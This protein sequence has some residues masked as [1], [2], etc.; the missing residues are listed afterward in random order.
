MMTLGQR[1]QN[2]RREKGLTQKQLAEILGLATG[3]I[4]QY[5][6]DKRQPRINQLQA[7]AAA[8]NVSTA[9]LLGIEPDEKFDK[10]IKHFPNA[11]AS[12]EDGKAVIKIVGYDP[13]T[14]VF[15][16]LSKLNKTGQEVAAERIEE[17]T[18]IPEYQ[19]ESSKD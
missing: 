1:I 13:K 4:Q 15:K 12:I 10:L 3:T 7:I 11:P 16:A 5:E 2:F 9:D 17:L 18:K 19:R 6:L 8:L 14:R